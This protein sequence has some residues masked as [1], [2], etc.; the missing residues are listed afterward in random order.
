MKGAVLVYRKFIAIRAIAL[1][2]QTAFDDIHPDAVPA[3]ATGGAG[4]PAHARP[5]R[6]RCRRRA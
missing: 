6:K 5:K 1:R 4:L 2:T 3:A